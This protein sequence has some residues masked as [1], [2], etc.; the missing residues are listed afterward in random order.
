MPETNLPSSKRNVDAYY[1]EKME[2]F[3]LS[4]SSLLLLK[5]I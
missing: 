2:S 4:K 1:K 5:A 3:S